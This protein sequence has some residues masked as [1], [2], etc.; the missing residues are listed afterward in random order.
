MRRCAEFIF[1][2]VVA[3]AAAPVLVLFAL[4][5]HMSMGSPV[6]FRQRRTGRNGRLFLLYK[7]RTMSCQCDSAGNLAPDDARLTPLGKWLRASSLDELPQL[8]NVLRGDMS[9]VGPRPLLPQYLPLYSTRQW[10][11]HEVRP[12]ITGWAQINGRNSTDWSTRLELDVWYVDHRS[13]GLDLKILFLTVLRV[14]R[15]S[16]VSHGGH[17]TMPEFRGEAGA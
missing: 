8:W 10:R 6:F 7:F 15:R 9:L 13:L 12:G 16:G 17:A 11:R 4:G 2:S 14:L 5:V 1:C 3:A